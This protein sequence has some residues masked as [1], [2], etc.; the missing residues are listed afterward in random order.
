ML[1]AAGGVGGVPL[2]YVFLLF[3]QKAFFEGH[4]VPD[5]LSQS[6]R[7]SVLWHLAESLVLDFSQSMSTAESL[8]F[9]KGPHVLLCVEEQCLLSHQVLFVFLQA[10]QLPRIVQIYLL[11]ILVLTHQLVLFSLVISILLQNVHAVVD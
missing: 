7:F 10:L 2:V 9:G 6:M 11:L 5:L 3:S 8:L 1:F 4:Q